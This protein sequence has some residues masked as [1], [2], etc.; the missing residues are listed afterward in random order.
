LSLWGSA[1]MFRSGL[2]PQHKDHT[3]KQATED[4]SDD[5]VARPMIFPRRADL[6]TEYRLTGG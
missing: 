6:Y 2:R 5:S 3:Q 4:R 1:A